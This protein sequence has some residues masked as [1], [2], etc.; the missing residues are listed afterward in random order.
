VI[1]EGEPKTEEVSDERKKGIKKNSVG[2]GL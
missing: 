1:E 2:V